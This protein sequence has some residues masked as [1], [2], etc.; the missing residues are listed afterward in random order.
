ME[1]KTKFNIGDNVYFLTSN[2]K[3]LDDKCVLNDGE[4]FV[5]CAEVI[6]I[7]IDVG[8]EKNLDIEYLVYD[9]NKWNKIYEKF[10]APDPTQLGLDVTNRYYL[11]GKKRKK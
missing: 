8:N 5:C 10:C 4:V 3:H 11:S 6:G 9:G 7:K 2:K 1:I